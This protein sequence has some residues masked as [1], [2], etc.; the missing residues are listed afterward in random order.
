MGIAALQ[1]ALRTRT[2]SD[3]TARTAALRR[4]RRAHEELPSGQ[5]ARLRAGIEEETDGVTL[6]V[7]RHSAPQFSLHPYG[8]PQDHRA[9]AE[10]S[11]PDSRTGGSFAQG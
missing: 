1:A 9:G 5:N 6:V 3:T 2:V 11:T 7:T 8:S 10:A 4:P